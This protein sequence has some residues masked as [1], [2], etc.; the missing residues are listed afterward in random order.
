MHTF[1]DRIITQVEQVIMVANTT[2]LHDAIHINDKGIKKQISKIERKANKILRQ[3]DLPKEY[4]NIEIELGMCN[5]DTIWIVTTYEH[6]ENVGSIF[7]IIATKADNEYGFDID[8][9]EIQKYLAAFQVDW[10][11]T[12][13]P[14]NLG[15]VEECCALWKDDFMLALSK[16]S[17]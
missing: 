15:T 14:D 1:F 17:S 16:K 12:G 4:H 9:K 11:A 3:M 2:D 7:H 10:V 13:V 6:T 8:I 5:K